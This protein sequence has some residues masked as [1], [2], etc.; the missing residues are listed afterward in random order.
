MSLDFEAIDDVSTLFPQ[1]FLVPFLI[2][3]LST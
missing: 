2:L 1:A 3:L